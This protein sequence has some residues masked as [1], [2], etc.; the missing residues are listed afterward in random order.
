MR[1]LRDCIFMNL[2]NNHLENYEGKVSNDILS[3]V[4]RE[5]QKR[6]CFNYYSYFSSSYTGKELI[7]S[8]NSVISKVIIKKYLI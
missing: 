3:F 4:K 6:R 1:F 8:P 5:K 7:F 2:T